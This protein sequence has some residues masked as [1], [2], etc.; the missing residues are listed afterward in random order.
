MK[1]STSLLVICL[2]V[3]GYFLS[4]PFVGY[5][6]LTL[7]PTTSKYPWL[8]NALAAFYTPTEAL[9]EH[10]PPYQSYLEL[11]AQA[12]NLSAKHSAP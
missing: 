3:V 10:F 11:V 12:L 6:Y 7:D 9:R 8:L 2:V 4:P 5:A 1:L